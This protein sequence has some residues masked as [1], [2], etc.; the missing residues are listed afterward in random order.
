MFSS[1]G[2]FNQLECPSQ[3]QCKLL[4]CIFSHLPKVQ[5]SLSVTD[6]SFHQN[7]KTDKTTTS[8][9]L[10]SGSACKKRRISN[11]SEYNEQ[12]EGLLAT[13]TASPG[14]QKLMQEKS[15]PG[16]N[17]SQATSLSSPIP[18]SAIKAVSPP[19]LHKVR[20]EP[21]QPMKPETKPFVRPTEQKKSE[22]RLIKPI[23]EVIEPLNPRVRLDLLY[24]GMY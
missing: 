17:R 12:D 5:S 6:A 14:S 9:S 4:N 15:N 23:R 19:P 21:N 18:E 10:D 7:A 3:S 24:H 11:S 20:P 8:H 16:S 13:K 1:I 22:P 2:L